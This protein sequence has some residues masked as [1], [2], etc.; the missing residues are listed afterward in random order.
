M[1]AQPSVREPHLLRYRDVLAQ[2]ISA[3]VAA[4]LVG[5]RRVHYVTIITLLNLYGKGRGIPISVIISI[6]DL[7]VLNEDYFT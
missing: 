5:H 4:C 3:D 7:D 1:T 2:S 6:I